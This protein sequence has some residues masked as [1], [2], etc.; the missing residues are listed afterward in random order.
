[1]SYP[2]MKIVLV[3]I[4]IPALICQALGNPCGEGSSLTSYCCESYSGPYPRGYVG[5]GCEPGKHCA[6]HLYTMCCQQLDSDRRTAYYCGE[7]QK[8]WVF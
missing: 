1:M 7:P 2:I 8:H 6:K 4:A 3:L 5:E